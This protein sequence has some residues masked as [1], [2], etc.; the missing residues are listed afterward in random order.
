MYYI[1]IIYINISAYII[2]LIISYFRWCNIMTA[3]SISLSFHINILCEKFH[4]YLNEPACF[5]A[6]HRP[7]VA[8]IPPHHNASSHFSSS[9]QLHQISFHITSSKQI[10]TIAP[11]FEKRCYIIHIFIP[12]PNVS[13]SMSYIS[14]YNLSARLLILS[15]LFWGHIMP[16]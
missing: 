4:H 14:H 9:S 11:R 13:L 1:E 10:I 2:Y 3:I 5:I 16:Q 6:T 12:I 7:H 8:I 15:I